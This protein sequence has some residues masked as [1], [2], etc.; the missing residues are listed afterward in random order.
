[1]VQRTLAII[2]PDA[3]KLNLA[4]AIITMIQK[5]KLKVIG[6][7]M[8]RLTETAAQNFYIVHKERPFFSSLIQHMS[9]GPVVVMALEGENAIACYRKLMGATNPVNAAEGTIRKRYA[10]DMEKNAV[11]G[12]DTPNAAVVEIAYFF[13]QLELIG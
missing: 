3:V 7:K 10:L 12:S 5:T 13:N 4:G 9:S 2:K 11:H 8:L 1:M 6:I